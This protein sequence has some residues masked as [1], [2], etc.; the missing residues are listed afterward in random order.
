MRYRNSLHIQ[1]FTQYLSEKS[2]L[3]TGEI[4]VPPVTGDLPLWTN[5]EWNTQQT[6]L[7][8]FK[9]AINKMLEMSRK[10]N[11]DSRI[12]LI[13]DPIKLNHID[14]NQAL[15]HLIGLHDFVRHEYKHLIIRNADE[16]RGCEADVVIYVG[17]GNMEAFSRAKLWL[18][19]VTYDIVQH[20][21]ERIKSLIS[22]FQHVDNTNGLYT[23]NAVY[24]N[25]LSQAVSKGLICKLDISDHPLFVEQPT[26]AL[27]G[28][29]SSF[30]ESMEMLNAF[31]DTDLV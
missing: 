28:A 4:C 14:Q 23:N 3:D 18:G 30:I 9:I 8:N 12:L 7:I 31:A 21:S 2:G 17:G 6:G 27:T 26:D 19:I 16:Y 22:N 15:P 24:R 20:E 11:S 25:L 1:N 29:E 5:I 13:E 10:C